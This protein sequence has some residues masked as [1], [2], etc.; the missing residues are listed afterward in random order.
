MVKAVF[1]NTAEIKSVPLYQSVKAPGR[2][3]VDCRQIMK[4]HRQVDDGTAA[5][6]YKMV[7]WAGIVIKMVSTQSPEAVL[8]NHAGLRQLIQ[9]AVYST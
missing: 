9:I 4:L 6:A 8:G 5:A 2:L 3:R 7:M 1:A